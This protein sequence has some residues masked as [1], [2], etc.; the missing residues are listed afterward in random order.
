MYA[1]GTLL[2]LKELLV[3]ATFAPNRA[4]RPGV[5]QVDLGPL[6]KKA[7]ELHDKSTAS[8]RIEYACPAFV[9]STKKLLLRNED[10]IGNTQDVSSTFEVTTRRNAKYLPRQLRQVDF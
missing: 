6:G 2:P 7:E 9:T 1:E 5:T 3:E 10:F 4:L 8:G